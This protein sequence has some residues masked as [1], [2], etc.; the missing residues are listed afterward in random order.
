MNRLDFIEPR[1]EI[2]VDPS[3]GSV[4]SGVPLRLTI[5]VLRTDAGCAP[6]AGARVDIWHA[7]A[8]GR[9]SD[10]SANGTSRCCTTSA[11]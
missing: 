11:P 6:A 9:Y 5:N 4:S 7:N 10:E 8:L 1:A 3:D 2:T